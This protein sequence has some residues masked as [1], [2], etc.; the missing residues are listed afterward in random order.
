ML[1]GHNR[2]KQEIS[3]GREIFGKLPKMLIISSGEKKRTWSFCG[4]RC[5][6]QYREREKRNANP[7]FVFCSI[8]GK[9]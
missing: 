6:N 9:I 8:L 4:N 3:I 2:L 1:P 5:N 7:G